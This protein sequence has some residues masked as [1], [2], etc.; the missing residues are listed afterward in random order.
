[1]PGMVWLTRTIDGMKLTCIDLG[2]Q[3]RTVDPGAMLH[4]SVTERNDQELALN[5]DHTRQLTQNIVLNLT[6]AADLVHFQ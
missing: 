4:E 6:C 3:T 5:D 2:V 1:M